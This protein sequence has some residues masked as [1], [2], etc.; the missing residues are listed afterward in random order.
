MGE[1]NKGY[2]GYYE[3]T[4]W[5]LETFSEHEIKYIIETFQP[6]NG[7]G[8]SLV[9]GN[10]TQTNETSISFLTNLSAWF[11]NEN[12]RTIGFEIINKAEELLSETSNL[13]DAHYLFQTKIE[14]LYKWRDDNDILN[15]I[16]NVC[17]QQIAISN[18]VKSQFIKENKREPLPFH[19]G[20]EQL[21]IIEEKR[22]N[23]QHAIDIS[24]KAMKEGWFGEW[25]NRIERCNKKLS[26]QK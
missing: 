6:I 23:Y 17:K 13:L 8:N 26:K 4:E 1:N 22:N 11:K 3:L 21:A 9:K 20:F 15:E 18:E 19:K 14:L 5:W 16:I 12:D 10:I 7:S 2:I 25:E 24:T